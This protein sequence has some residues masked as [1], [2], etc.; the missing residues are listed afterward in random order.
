MIVYVLVDDEQGKGF[1]DVLVRVIL[2]MRKLPSV[3]R[4]KKRTLTNV[5]GPE[6]DAAAEVRR[7]RPK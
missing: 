5:I 7:R 1:Y 3:R 4:D 6:E 2:V